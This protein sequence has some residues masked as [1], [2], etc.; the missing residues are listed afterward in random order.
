MDYNVRYILG[1][2]RSNGNDGRDL[3]LKRKIEVIELDAKKLGFWANIYQTLLTVD[4][5]TFF[6]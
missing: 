5:L 6:L 1:E 3:W 4:K 2:I